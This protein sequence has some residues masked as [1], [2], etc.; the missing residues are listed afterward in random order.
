[1]DHSVS[2]VVVQHER[3][4]EST[5]A[6]A[7]FRFDYVDFFSVRTPNASKRSIDQW[8]DAIARAAGHAGQFVWRVIC[9]LRL[10]DTAGHP[11]GW[12][13]GERGENWV[14]L[15]AASWFMTAR[16]VIETNEDEL[17]VAT[18]VRYDRPWAAV[19]WPLVAIGHR[20][21]MP[22]LLRAAAR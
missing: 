14:R 11:G 3:L 22:G 9:G 7:G 20:A 10:S 12:S 13:I 6:R 17:C 2:T 5:C 21:A 18:F 16:L 19:Y 4:P 1:M 8:L 15:E